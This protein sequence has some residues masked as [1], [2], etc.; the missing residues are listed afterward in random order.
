M[1]EIIF[2]KSLSHENS[3]ENF[4]IVFKFLFAYLI[5]LIFAP[6]AFHKYGGK[7][8]TR[9]KIGKCEINF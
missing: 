3:F 6:V 2:I 7:R 5:K 9:E 8:L 4:R 1:K